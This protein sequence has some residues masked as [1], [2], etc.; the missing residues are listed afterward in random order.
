MNQTSEMDCGMIEPMKP[1]RD[2]SKARA[3]RTLNK[4]RRWAQEMRDAGW[5]VEEPSEVR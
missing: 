3:A 4:H 2:P 5:K 1:G